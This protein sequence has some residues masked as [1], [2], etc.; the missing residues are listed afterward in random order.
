MESS[1]CVLIMQPHVSAQRISAR[2]RQAFTDSARPFRQSFAPEA[3][4]HPR[5]PIPMFLRDIDADAF[6]A[7]P[8]E[9]PVSLSCPLKGHP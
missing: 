9:L 5:A 1:A 4:D 6:Y 3:Q 7:C 2:N 8:T